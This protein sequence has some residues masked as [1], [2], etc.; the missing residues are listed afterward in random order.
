MRSWS[1]GSD[2]ATAAVCDASDGMGLLPFGAA[3][4]L[5]LYTVTQKLGGQRIAVC[6][7]AGMSLV[8]MFFWYGLEFAIRLSEARSGRG[9]R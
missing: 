3:L 8:A 9:A 1:A 7:G 4:G 5:D 6:I 2:A